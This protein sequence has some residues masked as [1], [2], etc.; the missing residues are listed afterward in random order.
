MYIGD[1][2]RVGVRAEPGNTSAPFKVITSGT[3]INI[4]QKTSGYV[5]IR[6]EDG[7]EG[8]IRDDYI[9]ETQPARARLDEIEKELTLK[10][11]SQQKLQQ[12]L[13]TAT[14]RSQALNQQ[15]DLLNN[16]IKTLRQRYASTRP[17]NSKA[18]VYMIIATLSLCGLSF[19][20][21]I[22]W[23]KQQVAKKL[24]GHSI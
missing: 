21:G 23:D 13:T 20:L 11:Q 22:L 5:R 4:L 9:S 15:I 7:T 18:W 8:W 6:T 2:L 24:G 14:N 19:I 3:V 1:N 10:Q 16:E 12:E 17:D